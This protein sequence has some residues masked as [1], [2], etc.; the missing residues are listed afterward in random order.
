MYTKAPDLSTEF[1]FFDF[2]SFGLAENGAC[3]TKKG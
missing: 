1:R 3:H 2:L